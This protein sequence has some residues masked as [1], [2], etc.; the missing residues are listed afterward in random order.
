MP[1]LNLSSRIRRNNHSQQNEPLLLSRRFEEFL[2][3]QNP[4]R[5]FIV[6]ILFLAVVAYLLTK[7]VFELYGFLEN[8]E[9]NGVLIRDPLLEYGLCGADWVTVNRT[10][11]GHKYCHRFFSEKLAH[12]DAEK[13]CQEHGAHLSG[14]SDQS[15]L[16]ILDKMLD[17]AK[18]NGTRFDNLDAVWI[19]A[20]RRKRCWTRKGIGERK[21]FNPNDKHPCSRRLV[22][23][24]ENRAAQNPPDFEGRW[25]TEMEPSFSGEAEMCVELLKGVKYRDN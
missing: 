7:G 5:Q 21:G 18:R 10:K 9:K 1:F 2:Q 3:S 6:L 22:F 11:T 24:W 19:G 23:E 15:E 14:F 13:K 12:D 17:D 20:R 4:K 16:D 8:R 25:I